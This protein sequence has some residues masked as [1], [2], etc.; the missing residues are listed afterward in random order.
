MTRVSRVSNGQYFLYIPVVGLFKLF[1]DQVL[2]FKVG[3]SVCRASVLFGRRFKGVSLKILHFIRNFVLAM[4]I[5]ATLNITLNFNFSLCIA[6]EV[7][8]ALGRK[9]LF[10]D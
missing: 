5:T 3:V 6:A 1:V 10:E 7:S 9:M 4:F 2:A 8:R